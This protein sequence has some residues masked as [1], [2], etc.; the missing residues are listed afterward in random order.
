MRESWNHLLRRHLQNVLLLTVRP[1]VYHE[2]WG[3]GVVFESVASYRRDWIWRDAG[4][5]QIRGKLNGQL[6]HLDLS[7]WP[8][9]STYFLGRWY[10]LQ[11]Q[12]IMRAVIRPNDVVIDVGA[13][14]G[15]FAL[16]A[17]PL[18]GAGGTVVCFE[19][20]PRCLAVLES[21]ISANSLKN[22]VVHKIG[23]GEFDGTLT[24]TV[25]LINSG[26]GTFGAS[27]YDG[28]HTYEVLVSVKRGDD[29]LSTVTPSFIKIDVEGFEC[30][31]LA[32]LGKTIN[33]GHPVILTEVD[34]R[35][36]EHANSSV[37]DL[38][39]IM[40][41]YGYE[42][43]GLFLRKLDGTYRVS[44]SKTWHADHPTDA[45]WMHSSDVERWLALFPPT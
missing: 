6:M 35:L 7:N 34:H 2:L 37:S 22:V 21:S 41:R 28:D 40:K 18:V 16:S 38:A 23:L 14:R 12:L 24:L 39:N 26:E 1:Y 32:G 31:V 25:P 10:D 20:N 33:R 45:I 5:R 19:P 15:M 43:F 11:T 8:D 36:L 44:L 17:A 3:W 42:G 4:E 29:M 13:N 27:L 30:R 9:R